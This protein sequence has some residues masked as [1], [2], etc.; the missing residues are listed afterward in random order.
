[1]KYCPY[2]SESISE[3]VEIC[4]VCKKTIDLKVIGRLFEPG[5]TSEVDKNVKRKIWFK[6]N[7]IKIIPVITLVVGLII[8]AAVIFFYSQ[9]HFASEIENYENQIGT[10]QEEIRQKET[11][12]SNA[13]SSLQSQLRDKD[14]IIEIIGEQKEILSRIINFTRSLSQNSVITANTPEDATNYRRNVLYLRNQFNDQQTQLAN[15]GFT[16][17]NTYDLITIPQLIVQ[18]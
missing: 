5:E 3:N 8:G 9:Q 1:M 6:E 4:P 17:I 2:C 11:N 14:R 10:L 12:A 16:P 18:Q 7:A 15:T 13:A